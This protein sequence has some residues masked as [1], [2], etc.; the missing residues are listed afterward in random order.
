MSEHI[1]WGSVDTPLGKVVVYSIDDVV[2]DVTVFPTLQ[3]TDVR[4]GVS[5]LTEEES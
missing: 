4:F 1:P 2:I 5:H 3:D